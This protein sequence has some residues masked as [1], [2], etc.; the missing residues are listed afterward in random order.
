M[1]PRWIAGVI[2]AGTAAIVAHTL[3]SGVLFL[4]GFAA[5]GYRLLSERRSPAV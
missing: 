1:P 4:F 3:I 2:I 5:L